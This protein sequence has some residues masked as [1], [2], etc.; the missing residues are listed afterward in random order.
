MSGVDEIDDLLSG[1]DDAIAKPVEAVADEVMNASS[2]GDLSSVLEELEIEH[3][4]VKI[5]EPERD[6][7]AEIVNEP[8]L[9]LTLEVLRL[10]VQIQLLYFSGVRGFRSEEEQPKRQKANQSVR[11]PSLHAGR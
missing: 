11:W 6:L 8:A 1:L 5:E 9:N 10:L 4:S 2:T 7:I 3:E